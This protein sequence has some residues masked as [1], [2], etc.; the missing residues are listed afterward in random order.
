MKCGFGCLWVIWGKTSGWRGVQPSNPRWKQAHDVRCNEPVL[1]SWL[2]LA[3]V[4]RCRGRGG[5]GLCLH[6]HQHRLSNQ[7]INS[8]ARI[9]TGRAN[10]CW[11]YFKHAWAQSHGLLLITCIRMLLHGIAAKEGLIA[12]LMGGRCSEE[13]GCM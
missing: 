7:P 8:Q 11:H 3:R 6:K 9:H 4:C 10:S 2:N 13:R 1:L 12:K 5:H